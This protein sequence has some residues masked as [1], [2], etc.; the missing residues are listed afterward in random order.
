VEK[1][2]VPI[3]LEFLDSEWDLPARGSAARNDP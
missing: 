2:L 1:D 3:I